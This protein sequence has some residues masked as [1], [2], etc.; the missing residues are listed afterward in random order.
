MSYVV[1]IITYFLRQRHIKEDN[2]NQFNLRA[3]QIKY[4]LGGKSYIRGLKKDYV[5]WARGGTSFLTDWST[6]VCKYLSLID[7]NFPLSSCLLSCFSRQ[8]TFT[9]FK[10]N[11]RYSSS[12][13]ISRK[14]MNP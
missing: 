7:N 1:V 13:C 12:V 3:L 11:K 6:W 8:E 10:N 4:K 5:W 2:L 14:Q 9:L